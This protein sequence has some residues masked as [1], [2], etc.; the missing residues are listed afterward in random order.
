MA[1]PSSPAPTPLETGPHTL[2]LRVPSWNAIVFYVQ[3][4]WIWNRTKTEV[5]TSRTRTKGQITPCASSLFAAES[6][7][8]GHLVQLAN[9]NPVDRILSQVV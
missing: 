9:Y 3:G 6:H 5:I 1:K 8:L 2:V 4:Y 7:H